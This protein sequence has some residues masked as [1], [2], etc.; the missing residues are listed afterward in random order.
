[1]ELDRAHLDDGNIEA[2]AR[3]RQAPKVKNTIS[4]NMTR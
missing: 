4:L 3:E 2:L 1:M